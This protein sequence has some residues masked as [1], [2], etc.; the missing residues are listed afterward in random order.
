MDAG[1]LDID[2]QDEI[3]IDTTTSDGHIA[4]TSAHTAGQSILISA[5]ADSGS[6]LDID[7]GIIDIDAQ[8]EYKLDATGISLDSDA[9]SNFSTSAGSL[10]L[11]GAGGINIGTTA[12]VPIDMN[13]TTLDIDASGLISL[14]S[15]GGRIDIATQNQDYNVN[16]ATGGSRTVQLVFQ[17]AQIL[18]HLI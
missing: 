11:Y 9:A 15:S 10:T 12:D 3:T 17:M 4:I 1:K 8:G 18:Q 2:V 6:I 5:N 14:D 16:L 13:S 7:A